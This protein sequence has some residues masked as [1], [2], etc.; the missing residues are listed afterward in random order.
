M[1]TAVNTKRVEGRRD[2]HYDS[3]DELLE[4]IRRLTDSKHHTIGNWSLAQI[5]DHLA[6]AAAI[7]VDGASFRLPWPMSVLMRTFMK[8]RFLTKSLPSGFKTSH[9]RSSTWSVKSIA[10]AKPSSALRTRC[11]VI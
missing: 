9:R 7:Q 2:L 5:V 3:Y 11:W 10:A 4:D 6:R 1:S 8:K